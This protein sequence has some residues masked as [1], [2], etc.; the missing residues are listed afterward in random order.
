VD[1]V[2]RAIDALTD[3]PEE[4]EEIR[5]TEFEA[6][7]PVIMVTLYGNADEDAMK[8]AIRQARDELKTLPGMGEILFSGVR[9]YEIRIDVSASALLEHR[10]SLPQVSDAV[11]SWMADVPGGSVRTGVGDVRVRTTGVPERA[12]AIRR[13]VVKATPD[14]QSLRVGDIAEVREHYVDEQ[15][16][17]RFGRYEDEGAR[18]PARP[19]VSLTVFKV[20]EQDAVKIAEMTRA[21]VAGRQG[22]PF[23]A[24]IT[25]R[26]FG[27]LNKMSSK[28][29]AQTSALRTLRRQ[30]YDLGRSSPD[31]L[32]GSLSTHSDL[33]R[34]I[35]GRLD[36]LM[37]NARWG[38][39]LVFLTLLVFL[40]WRVALWVGVGLVIAVSGT[41]VV[42]NAIGITLNLLT[43]FGLI[44]VLGLLVD[45]AIVVAENV[46]ARHDRNE[47]ALV[48]AV[49]GTE[50]VLWP[51]VA[52]VL[53]TI[54][55]F[56]PLRFVPAAPTAHPA[57]LHHGGGLPGHPD[58]LRGHGGRRPRRVHVPALLRHRDRHRGPADAHRH[59]HRAHR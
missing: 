44:V 28:G 8:R 31:P 40:N 45:D 48:A 32:P 39:L 3:L 23:E 58:R 10:L 53:T 59:R 9:D 4:A 35:E 52:T 11:R 41:L 29:D 17:T 27:L 49:K 50:Q 42:M 19:S 26:L 15:L 5:V 6:R 25:D 24:R 30:A 16:I 1:E 46:Q 33:A 55:A 2:E 56:M 54:V 21:Y 37:R 13:I 43:M 38:A 22:E 47:P 7:L 57:A 18:Q 34:F 14:G 51:V 20:G 12:E 36:L